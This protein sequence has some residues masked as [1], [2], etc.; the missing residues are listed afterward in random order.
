MTYGA[1]ARAA[2][3]PPQPETTSRR[4]LLIRPD[5]LGIAIESGRVPPSAQGVRHFT[6]S[7]SISGEWRP[8]RR[9]P[10]SHDRV[11]STSK[12]NPFLARVSITD[13][14]TSYLPQSAQSTDSPPLP[15]S[16]T[17]A[18]PPQIKQAIV[19]P[20]PSSVSLHGSLR[21]ECASGHSLHRP[22]HEE[23]AD[24]AGQL[25][26]V[27]AHGAIRTEDTAGPLAECMTRPSAGDSGRGQ[28]K[29]E[30][31]RTVWL[32]GGTWR[33]LRRP[34]VRFIPET[35]NWRP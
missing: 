35:A 25:H 12:P 2:D 11:W 18:V 21:I 31:H 9:W 15:Y 3:A 26:S 7:A 4:V 17:G 30:G 32:T 14:A 8:E 34:L 33:A 1:T 10:C 24:Q 28:Q 23:P 16:Q 5:F 29:P 6:E 20:P 19:R 13:S 22:G 27:C